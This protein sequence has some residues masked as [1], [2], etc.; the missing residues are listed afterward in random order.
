LVPANHLV[1]DWL[2]LLAIGLAVDGAVEAPAWRRAAARGLAREAGRQVEPDGAAFE[3][4]T[5][6]HRFTLELLLA[7]DRLGRAA[8]LGLGPANH[9]V[10]D[11]LGLLAIGLAVDGA[12]E[13]PAWRR[14]AARGLARE[15]GR[16]VE[17]D[18]AAFEASTGYHR[19]T[20][21]LLLA[22]D[23]LGRAA[24]LGLG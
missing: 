18:G 11:W 20:L 23:R 1:A 17:P 6:Y 16:Q 15:A 14:A 5:G 24:R 22:A 13:A 19:F 2:G 9:L 21:E 10:A 8:R 4:S 12:V 3:A 7:A